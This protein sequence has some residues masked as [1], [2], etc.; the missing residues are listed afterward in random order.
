MNTVD[1][2]IRIKCLIEMALESQISW[3]TLD[4]IVNGLT[5]T[6]EKSKQINRALLKEFENHQSIC[7]IKRCN[8]DN[9]DISEDV[10]E[11]H[12]NPSNAD[13][14][15][16]IQGNNYEEKIQSVEGKNA[17]EKVI[18][19]E[20]DGLGTDHNEEN[21]SS[22]HNLSEGDFSGAESID[23]EAN[24]ISKKID[25][26]EAFKGQFY[27]FV[28]DDSNRKSKADDEE[29]VENKNKEVSSKITEDISSR[30]NSKC[31]TCGKFFRDKFQLNRHI[32][33]HTGEKPFQCKT[34]KKGFTQECNLKKHE[35]IHTGE[36]PFQCETCNRCFFDQAKLTRHERTHT[37]ERPYKC[38]T[39]KTT[40]TRRSSLTMHLKKQHQNAQRTKNMG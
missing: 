36:K 8:V 37:G 31:E 35:M 40:F 28:G 29:F 30:K 5:P 26:V 17:P 3:P 15:K 33:I 21:V 13:E 10:I 12:E 16:L 2:S 23:E 11:V 38:E 1:M 20:C 9:D 18:G 7:L 25:L 34:C 4:L 22:E 24:D 32:R 27:M 6:L 14:V 39:C 19:M